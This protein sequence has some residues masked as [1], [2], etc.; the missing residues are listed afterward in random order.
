M[1]KRKKTNKKTKKKK[2]QATQV[3]RVSETKSSDYVFGGLEKIDISPTGVSIK[4]T[5]ELAL[6]YA[7]NY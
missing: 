7:F 2:G 5:P 3:S 1:A 4:N 6:K